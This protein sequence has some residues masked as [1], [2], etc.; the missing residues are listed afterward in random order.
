MESQLDELDTLM[1]VAR[2]C[3]VSTDMLIEW[4]R[5]QLITPK[6]Q[7][8][9]ETI[10]TVRRIRRLSNLGVNTAGVQMIL[11]MRQQLIQHQAEITRVQQEIDELRQF[12]EQEI[13]RLMRQFASDL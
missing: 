4:I 5:E 11:Y 3:G 8:D 6:E 10:E 13:A 9:D 2:Q 12:H 7:W 1:R